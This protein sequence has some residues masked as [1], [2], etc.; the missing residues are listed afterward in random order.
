MWYVDMLKVQSLPTE[1][2]GGGNKEASI[3]CE[4]IK[5]VDRTGM[6]LYVKRDCV[7]VTVCYVRL[8]G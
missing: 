8:R 5:G 4:I 3:G 7:T 1:R 2:N 6:R